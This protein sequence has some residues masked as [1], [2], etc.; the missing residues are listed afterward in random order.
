[1]VLFVDTAFWFSLWLR[2]VKMRNSLSLSLLS[3]LKRKEGRMWSFSACFLAFPSGRPL[4]PSLLRF[5]SARQ[6]PHSLLLLSFPSSGQPTSFSSSSPL[7]THSSFKVGFWAA[8]RSRRARK[9]G[10]QNAGEKLTRWSQAQ[11]C[12][13]TARV[14]SLRCHYNYSMVTTLC[15]TKYSANIY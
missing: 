7:L 12:N 15:G 3:W 10:R 13:S 2:S 6:L 5:H 11:A 8:D 1:M 14:W 4:S 9:E